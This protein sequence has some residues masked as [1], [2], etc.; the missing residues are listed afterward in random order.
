MASGDMVEAMVVSAIKLS[1]ATFRKIE[2]NLY[3]AFG[4]NMAAV[5]IAILGLLHPVIAEAALERII[6]HKSS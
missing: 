4:Y 6:G 2:Q 1:R 5:P 3:W